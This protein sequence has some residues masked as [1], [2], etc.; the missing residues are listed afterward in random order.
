MRI[1]IDA[2]SW[3][4]DR[5][6]GRYT[7]EIVTAMVTETPHHQFVCI[8]DDRSAERF[9]IQSPNVQRAVVAQR[10]APTVAASTGSRRSL[11]DMARLSSAVW[12]ARLDA[13]YSP[14][15]Y[16]YF[17]VPPGLPFVVTIH[18]AIAERFPS[19]TLPTWRDRWSWRAKVRLAILQARTVLTVSDYAA[20]QIEQY[21]GVPRRRTRVTLEGVADAFRPS[22]SPSEFDDVAARLELTEW[23]AGARWVVYVGGFGP[24]KHVDVLVRAHAEVLRRRPGLRLRLLLVGA[25]KDGFHEETAAIDSAIRS[26]G[27]EGDVRWLGF[28]PDEDLRHLHANA[29]ALA[30]VSAS[31]GFGLP[32]VECARCGTPVIATTESP[33][34][35][36][37]AGG[38]L[39]V[40]PG[41]PGPVADAIERL[42]ADEAARRTLGARA[43]E[44]AGELSWRRAARVALDALEAA[45]N[46][47]EK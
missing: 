25:R 14:S 46:R 41:D 3:A 39:F 26:A 27:T 15:V 11:G 2:T 42:V 29:L 6:Y 47:A 12:R 23:L 34:P 8:L 1:G 36:L 44:R 31:E 20:G 16:G 18:D 4:N 22:A 33:L 7:R 24:H 32:A 13:F 17:P 9:T 5:G 37:L 10:V 38:G 28:L 19:L 40:P 35:S 30:L 43:R 21:L 45:A